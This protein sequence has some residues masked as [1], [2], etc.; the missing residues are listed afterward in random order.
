[1][2]SFPRPSAFRTSALTAL[3]ITGGLTS[4]AFAQDKEKKPRPED[5]E[6]WNPVPPVVTPA[7][8]SKEPTALPPSDAVVLFDGKNLDA[9]VA[10]GTPAI[11]SASKRASNLGMKRCAVGRM[12]QSLAGQIM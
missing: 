2:P 11:I 8:A 1:M 10:V 4:L 12:P 6:V 9:W 5:T 7:P 3:L